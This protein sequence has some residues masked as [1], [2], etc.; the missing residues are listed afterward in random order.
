VVAVKAPRPADSKSPGTVVLHPAAAWPTPTAQI[1]LDGRRYLAFPQPT[2]KASGVPL[3]KEVLD[4][5]VGELGLAGRRYVVVPAEACG[6]HPT[7]D[8]GPAPV[9]VLTPREL[10]VVL[11]VASGH[12]NKEIADQLK[13]SEWTVST[14]LRRVFAKLGVESR[15]A[16]V[17]RCS[18]LI[19]GAG[20]PQARA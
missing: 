11:L 9:D 13:I 14:H 20:P 16:M 18:E 4:R 8:N 5:K 1:E 2:A 19:R 3:P 10:Q 6:R 7:G 17:Y 15:A 12:V